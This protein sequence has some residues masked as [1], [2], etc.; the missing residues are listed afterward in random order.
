MSVLQIVATI[1]IFDY[2]YD[3]NGKPLINERVVISGPLPVPGTNQAPVVNI[4]PTTITV[5]T[6]KNGYWSA[7]VVPNAGMNPAGTLY[8]VNSPTKGAYEISVPSAG[9][10][11]QASS[12]A[13][14]SPSGS[15]VAQTFQ[16][17]ITI[18]GLLTAAGGLTISGFTQGSVLFVGAGAAVSQ[19]NA[20]LFYDATNKRFGIGTATPLSSLHV[21]PT[22]VSGSSVEAIRGDNGEAG[23]AIGSGTDLR[24]WYASSSKELGRIASVIRSA[25]DGSQSDMVFYTRKTETIN[26]RLRLT[27]DG[28]LVSSGATP[29]LGALQAGISSQSIIGSDMRFLVTLM[30]TAAAPAANSSIAIVNFVSVF[31]NIPVVL[32]TE[33]SVL[34]GTV[35]VM[36]PGLISTSSITIFNGYGA[37]PNSVT[38]I[39]NGMVIG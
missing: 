19:D 15:P 4:A 24:L 27:A 23:Y 20:S 25:T 7:P 39:I 30:T 16:G 6:D 12:L 5:Q 21:R 3:A 9:G 8:A 28:H 38:E 17:A 37:L 34:G 36:M 33:Q 13:T 22:G 11:F 31:A 32:L 26:E 29:T 14:V 10:P 18:N 35:R 2:E 1:S